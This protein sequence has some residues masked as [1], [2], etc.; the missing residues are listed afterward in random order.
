MGT[1]AKKSLEAVLAEF[2]KGIAHHRA[3]GATEERIRQI[4]GEAIYLAFQQ[5]K[6][7]ELRAWL[8]DEFSE[9]ARAAPIVTNHPASRILH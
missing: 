8:C 9:A 7:P 3:Q 5:V 4:L 6:D 2:R 1:K